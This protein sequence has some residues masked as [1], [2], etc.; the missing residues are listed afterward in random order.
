MGA[1][2]GGRW[3]YILL[4]AGGRYYVGETRDVTARFAQHLS[5]GNR[6]SAWTSLYE[7][8]EVVH[9]FAQTSLHD[10][11][12][13]TLDLMAEYGIRNVRGGSWSAVR[14]SKSARRMAKQRLATM[15]RLCYRCK[16]PGHCANACP[17]HFADRSSNGNHNAPVRDWIDH[18]SEDDAPPLPTPNSALA[19]PT[20]ATRRLAGPSSNSDLTGAA[21]LSVASRGFSF[22][23]DD[24]G[25]SGNAAQ[26]AQMRPPRPQSDP[27]CLFDA[28]PSVVANAGA[29]RATSRPRPRLA[30]RPSTDMQIDESGRR[31]DPLAALIAA[32][33]ARAT[34][35]RVTAG[36]HMAA[37]TRGRFFPE[38]GASPGMLRGGPRPATLTCDRCGRSGHAPTNCYARQHALGHFLAPR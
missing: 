2:A 26:D 3:I 25:T 38:A 33:A 27:E 5:G 16:R 17:A 28:A 21:S 1:S 34:V 11:D 30:S 10:E 15:Q 4:C 20:A 22:A 31:V 23:A 13:T 24:G 32:A 12:T 36:A 29:G 19:T 6:G 8:L 35:P 18:D 37:P 7:P 9:S 14:L